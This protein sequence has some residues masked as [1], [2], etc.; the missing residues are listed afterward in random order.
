LTGLAIAAIDLGPIDAVLVSHDPATTSTPPAGPCS[1]RLAPSSPPPPAPAGWAATPAA[2][3]NGHQERHRLD[4]L[5]EFVTEDANP[6]NHLGVARVTARLPH[7]AAGCRGAPGRHP[8]VGSVY[9]HNT[10]STDAYLPSL[11]AAVLVTSADP[12]ISGAERAFLERVTEHSVRLFV[13]LNKADYL[14]AE[15]LEGIVA[16]TER[17]VRE[18]LPD[19]PGPA[20]PL[21]ARPG[22]GD[23][24]GV[25]RFADDLARF[26]RQ[27]GWRW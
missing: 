17:V 11:D 5:A 24:T 1:R 6:G 2:S 15:D 8:G 4:R 25:R 14:A 3:S 12:P 23:P 7:P 21:S 9:E 13:V 26:L 16:F 27:S 20:Y 18:V 22:V 10:R 19:W